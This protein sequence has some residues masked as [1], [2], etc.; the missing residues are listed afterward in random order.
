MIDEVSEDALKTKVNEYIRSIR[1]EELNKKFKKE[2]RFPQDFKIEDNDFHT[3]KI[4][5]RALGLISESIKKRGIH[6]RNKYWTL[7]PYGDNVMTKLRAIKK[8]K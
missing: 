1:F 4:Q 8:K 2:N 5:F 6:D 7:S 3:L